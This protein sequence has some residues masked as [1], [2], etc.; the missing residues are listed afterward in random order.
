VASQVTAE[1]VL[2]LRPTISAR[3]H[4]HHGRAE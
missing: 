4:D 2:E 1:L 3:R